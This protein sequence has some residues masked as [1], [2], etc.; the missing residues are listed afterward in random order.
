MN[1]P[2][3]SRAHSRVRV[4]VSVVCAPA[5][6]SP[7]DS[8]LALAL[9][10]RA[11]S[12][13]NPVHKHKNTNAH[14]HTMHI[15]T[16]R[17]VQCCAQRHAVLS[18]RS[19]WAQT[20]TRIRRSHRIA[21]LVL[22]LVRLTA[23]AVRTRAHSLYSTRAVAVL[24]L[25]HSLILSESSA[26]CRVA[27]RRPPLQSLHLSFTSPSLAARR[28]PLHLP[29]CAL[30]SL[31]EYCESTVRTLTRARIVY[32]TF[33]TRIARRRSQHKHTKHR[34]QGKHTKTQHARAARERKRAPRSSR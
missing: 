9:C 33:R 8:C 18:E 11:R 30:F 23:R 12:H 14:A 16:Q 15:C 10:S 5:T 1:N 6:R 26:S 20:H 25:T 7:P 34:E 28:S 31:Y 32:C 21:S 22:V 29:P 4:C 3:R 2:Q 19:T 17:T 27:S 13:E 24:S